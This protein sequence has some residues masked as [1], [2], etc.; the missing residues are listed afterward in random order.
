ME[1]FDFGYQVVYGT[2]VLP[3][4]D[5]YIKLAEEAFAVA[6]TAA[7]PGSFLVD[8]LPIC[9]S[10]LLDLGSPSH[11]RAVKYVPEWMPGAGCRKKTRI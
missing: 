10:L 11:T 9:M 5:P 7:N 1:H 3:T 4:G 2:R 8:T 6:L